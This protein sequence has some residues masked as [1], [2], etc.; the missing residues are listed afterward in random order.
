MSS[1]NRTFSPLSQLDYGIGWDHAITLPPHVAKDE[2]VWVVLK[3]RNGNALV[4]YCTDIANQAV[5]LFGNYV[6]YSLVHK[7]SSFSS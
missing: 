5:L 4:H 6:F 3:P 7:I 1:A 2:S